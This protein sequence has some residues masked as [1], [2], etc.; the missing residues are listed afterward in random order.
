MP[1]TRLTVRQ[2]FLL[3][4][5]KNGCWR[6]TGAKTKAGYGRFKLDGVNCYAHRVAYMLWSGDIES[7]EDVMHLCDTN[8]CVRPNHLK[9]G[10]VQENNAYKYSEKY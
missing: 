7:D 3:H 5:E 6:W 1:R 9:K 8:N 4:V 2:R 10:T